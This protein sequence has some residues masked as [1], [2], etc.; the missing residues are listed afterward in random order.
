MANKRGMSYRKRV[1]DINRIYDRYAQSGLSNIGNMAT[2][3]ISGL[4]D[5]RAHFLQHNERHGG[6]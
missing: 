1:E 6:A 3:H 5:Q 2:V 4:L